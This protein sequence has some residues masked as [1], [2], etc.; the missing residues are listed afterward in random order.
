MPKWPGFVGG[1]G[2][3][4][5]LVG[6]GEDT[7]N[8][9]VERLPKDAT[10]EA[11][12]LP[13]PGF[14]YW[15]MATTD[16]GTRA[17]VSIANNRLFAVI[18]AG[19]WEF[20]VNGNAT[21]RGT[22]SLDANP[23]QLAY[24]GVVGGQMAIAS[25]GNIFSYDLTTNVLSGPYLAGGYTHVAYASGFGLAFNS[26]TGKVNLSNLNNLTVWNAAQFF[27]RSLFADPWR[28]M[29]VDQNNLVWLVGTDSFEVWYNTGQ[30]T[31]PWA[32]LSGLVGVI[33]IVGPFAYA[34]AQVGNVWL[35]RNQAGQGLLVQT[36]GGAPESVS[37]RAMATAVAGYSRNGG[38][39]DTEI[40]HHQTDA[41]LFT[42]LTFP[43]GGTWCYDQTEQSWTRRGHW[44]PQTG[45][46]DPWAPR[47]HV[48]AYGKHLTGDRTTG[49]IAEMDPS[50]ATELD[51]TG[52]RRLRR[53]PALVSE[54]RRTSI[55]QIEL[56]MDVG[57]ADQTGQGAAPTVMLRISDDAGLTWGNELRASTGAAGAW[58]TRVYWTRLGLIN[59]AVAE[60]TFS[61]PVPF[62]VV[63][64]YVN[65]LESA[66]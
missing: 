10:N 64:A 4:S 53:T 40:L 50:F 21:R 28:A 15:G 23:A 9:Y 8:L 32:P 5:T 26:S 11:A 30:G 20:D 2:T 33:G 31:Q 56:L 47:C 18:G 19:L 24:N 48:M 58:R 52:I 44:N 59:H 7:V 57:L 3:A 61:D 42:N 27:Q 60:F 63:D 51:G 13:T 54:K 45:R 39:A 16:V 35:S 22:V 46:Y 12:L 34:V 43:R 29:F 65:N 62:R 17:M 66:A 6:A 55:D 38:L 25:G 37:S 49:M 36:R 41:H 1:A 14:R